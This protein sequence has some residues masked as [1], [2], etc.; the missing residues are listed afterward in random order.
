MI[1][2]VYVEKKR[3]FSVAADHLL[4]DLKS[5]LSL[6]G[7]TGVRVIIRYDIEDISDRVYKEAL[8]TVFSEPPVDNF[9]QENID[10]TNEKSFAVE[11]LPGQYDQRADSAEQCIQIMAPGENPSIKTAMQYVFSGEIT[12]ND[13]DKIKK[14]LI[15]PVDS[16]EAKLEK[17]ETLHE[18]EV[19]PADVVYFN[20][21]IRKSESEIKEL[22]KTL[23]LAMSDLDLLHCQKYF[24]DEEKRDPSI[25]EIKMLDTYWSDHCRHTTF[26]TRLK[27]I[28]F[29]D[30]K[31]SKPIKESYDLYLKTR[32]RLYVGKDKDISLMDMAV[33]AAKDL[34]SRGLME[35]LEESE[36]VNACSIIVPA[37]IDGVEEEW[38][39]QFKN[40]THNHPTEIEPFGGAATCLGGCIRDPLSGRS[41]VYQAMRVTGAGSPLTA[42]EDTIPGK[43][44]QRKICTEAAHG[45]SSYGNQIGLATGNVTEIYHEGYTA[46]RMEIGAVIAAAPR[47]NVTRDSAAPGDIIVLTGGK[48]GRDGC[49][50]ATGSS[51][52][53]TEESIETS[54]AE[55]QKGNPPVERKIQRLFRNPEASKMIKI[56][57]DFGAGGISVAIAELADGLIIDLDVVP[58]KYNGLDG[59]ELTISE[60]QERMAVVL[61]PKDVKRFIDLCEEENLEAVEVAVVTKEPRVKINW[62]GK[63]IVSMARSFINTNGVLQDMDIES[64]SPNENNSWFKNSA[65]V[66]STGSIKKDWLNNLSDLNVCSQKGLIETFDSTIG[67]S[68]VLLP[69]GGKTQQTP[70]DVMCAKIPVLKG[71][72]SN[73][74]LMSFGFDPDLSS[75]SP[76]HGAA[77]AVVES[78]AKIVAAGGELSEIRLTFQEYFERL[79]TDPVKWGKPFNALLGA[80][81]AQTELKI[82]AIGG[83]D[84]MSGTFEELHVPPTLVSF[85]VAPVDVNHVISPEFKSSG[86]SVVYIP[87]PK[88]EFD[89][90]NY[91]MVEKLFNNITNLIKSEVILSAQTVRKGG[92]ASAISKMAF[93]NQIGVELNNTLNIEELLK[94]NLSSFIVEVKN[95]DEL[96]DIDY[97]VIGTTISEPVIKVL[98]ESIKLDKM[99]TTWEKTLQDVYPIRVEDRQKEVKVSYMVDKTIKPRVK[100]ENP[101]VI[102]PV[103]PGTNCEYD[104]AKAFTDAG[105]IAETFVIN[106][107]S[108]DHIKES[109][110][111]MVE[112]ID[113]SQIIMIPGGFSAGD[114]PEG[115]AKFI[116]AFFRNPEIKDA[117]HR[118]LHQR[119]GLMMGICNGF[120]AL[121]KLGLVP[122][123][124]IRDIDE[125]DPTLTYNTIGRHISMMAETEVVSNLSPWLSQCSV[126]DRHQI[127]LSHGEGRFII[128]E[129]LA[130]KLIDNG[131]IAT[132]YKGKN[133]NGSVMAIEGIT[134]PDGRVFGKMGHSERVGSNVC[135]NIYG[136]KDQAIFKAGVNY[137][138]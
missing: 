24:R 15:N 59:T 95:E 29:D 32:E 4:Q 22:R 62:R 99:I 105:A 34:R 51:K 10:L 43:L 26:M 11:Y 7:L 104:T 97:Q 110:S 137:F 40:E 136:N 57:N 89:I 111:Q 86:N 123:G 134:S 91:P 56:C 67:A 3:D 120:Q 1:K 87:L 84:S 130:K 53:H 135:K 98:G 127:A 80:Y 106:N 121:V 44:P 116:A 19:I 112:K 131:Q 119:D 85:A 128:D 115:S 68:S 17:P 90:P 66:K 20:N 27:N 71:D 38:L 41:Y 129:T 109:I 107:L 31:Y 8:T 103:F 75:W 126:G 60:S 14:Y 47:S 54:G 69:F 64:K 70:T 100:V 18:V 76:F 122:Y 12:D 61:D 102:I 88:D 46:K 114:E 124:E 101:R 118:L 74:T 96:I 55:V 93:G 72:T 63:E 133:P 78:A 50:G 117:V 48:T 5:H 92:I 49:G 36:E 30:G 81:K 21:F 73:G 13:L 33:L 39:I 25:T 58:K 108:E 82:G 2:R 45:Y 77:Y 94:T 42:I 132:Q 37:V 79:G 28:T 35:N 23:G 125:H 6:T 83:K 16:R 52:E 9:Y 138:K 113:N 65:V